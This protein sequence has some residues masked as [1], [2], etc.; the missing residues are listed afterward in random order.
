M[1]VVLFSCFLLSSHGEAFE[2]YNSYFI[3]D[4][5]RIVAQ[6]IRKNACV[7]A[8][9]HSHNELSCSVNVTSDSNS[10]IYTSNGSLGF[11]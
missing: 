8:I 2:L 6:Q 7:Q 5:T 1:V 9:V 4:L 11:P 10:M 3:T